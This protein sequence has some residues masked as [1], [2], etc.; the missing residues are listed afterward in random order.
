MYNR[1][2]L[3]GRLVRDPELRYTPGGSAVVTLRLAVNDSRRGREGQQREETLFIDVVVWGAQAE[4]VNRYLARGRPVLVDG[5]LRMETW[6][7]K[8]GNNRV[9][10]RVVAN[11]VVFLG[12][13]S[14]E[15][16]PE[17]APEIAESAGTFDVPPPFGENAD[18][19]EPPF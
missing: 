7:D 3:V 11:R 15:P 12:E 18:D 10:Y 14:G 8:D 5:R 2:I 13:R 4:A 16:S 1:V 17:S 9:S 19:D 6:K